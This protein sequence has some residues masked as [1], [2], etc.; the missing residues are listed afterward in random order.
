M[1]KI[2][3][4]TQGAYG[5]IYEAKDGTDTVV[6]K[7]N[8]VDEEAMGV[9]SIREVDIMVTLRGHP[10][11]VELKAISIGDPFTGAVLSPIR[12]MQ[13]KD[14]RIHTVM[15]KADY[16]LKEAIKS[17]RIPSSRFVFVIAHMLLGLEYMHNY[18]IIHRDIKAENVLLFSS[19]SPSKATSG[20]ICAVKLCDFGLSK[21]DTA[22]AP[23]TPKV[24][25]YTHRAPEIICNYNHTYTID[26]WA[27]GCV[28]YEMLSKETLF[29][30]HSDNDILL[31]RTILDNLHYPVT[32]K[33]LRKLC[34]VTLS[35][36]DIKQGIKI[37]S[38]T[39]IKTPR[40]CD[41]K[42]G[43]H[44]RMTLDDRL[45]KRCKVEDIPYYND[46]LDL[47]HHLLIFDPDLRFTSTQALNHKYFDSYRQEITRIRKEYLLP[48]KD[49]VIPIYKCLERRWVTNLAF[50]LWNYQE[51]IDWY[52]DRTI[53]QAID[54]FDRYLYAKMKEVSPSAEE[55]P[56]PNP[57]MA[58]G[59][60]HTYRDT[61]I[62]FC[63][64]LYMATKYFTT[65]NK[66]FSFADITN[67]ALQDI[68]LD[69]AIIRQ[70]E[71]FELSLLKFG[72]EY[73][74][75]RETCYEIAGK[76]GILSYD[77]VRKLLLFYGNVGQDG[78]VEESNGEIIYK[79]YLAQKDKT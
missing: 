26:T 33:D 20:E 62:L 52:Q 37:P 38:L 14:D 12:D 42:V 50:Q 46:L 68:T 1:H 9:C 28:I 16:N 65:V 64:C 45:R 76:K 32:D 4:V 24:V 44:P 2:A 18:G 61:S 78:T 13:G 11:I 49:F 39:E 36:E 69:E 70:A 67:I 47:L 58:R 7:R 29:R 22:A 21:I 34:P 17:D 31:L 41:I 27:I 48:R 77:E 66:H 15:E 40:L 71:Q 54:V 23:S 55:F 43:T 59:K 53:F 72:L 3:K 60:I 8:I 63:C 6:V 51:K 73:R 57:V 79:L 19:P 30:A 10:S 74:F 35:S 75:Y 5:K 25:T 56:S